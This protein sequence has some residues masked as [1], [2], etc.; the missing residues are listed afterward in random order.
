LSWS[1]IDHA[2]I[3][4]SNVLNGTVVRLDVSVSPTTVS[5]TNNTLIATGYQHGLSDVAFV[6]GPTGLAYD[7]NADVLY[8]ASTMDNKIFAI[9]NAEHRT[10]PP[11]NGT[12]VVIYQD[13]AHLRGPL[14][15]ALAPNG[16]LVTA[17]GDAVNPPPANP[18]PLPSQL[19]E[20]TKQGQFVGQLSID[21]VAGAAVSRCRGGGGL[22]MSSPEFLFPPWSPWFAV[23]AV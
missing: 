7:E 17:N 12:G 20:F 6:L 9:S 5:V 16:H 10:A 11:S 15:L 21:P 19:V 14:A 23:A 18:P 4:V 22:P 1:A 2:S 13:N 8:V 3:F